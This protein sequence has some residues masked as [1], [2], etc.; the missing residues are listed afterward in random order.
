MSPLRATILS[1]GAVSLG[2]GASA[3]GAGEGA[4]E[5][6]PAS[7]YLGATSCTSCHSSQG[8]K[9]RDGPHAQAS[10]SLGASTGRAPCERCH[11]T[12]LV[13]GRVVLANVQCEACHGAGRYYAAEDIMRNPELSTKLGLRRPR[14]DEELVQLCQQCHIEETTLSPFDALEAWARIGH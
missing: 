4:A 8:D 9:W 6:W 13:R 11:G 5:S 12:E 10:A 14:D 1:L 7:D 2:T 3:A